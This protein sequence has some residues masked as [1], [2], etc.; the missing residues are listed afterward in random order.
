M[1]P[2]FP[3]EPTPARARVRMVANQLRRRDITD[4]RVL[5]AMEQVPRD[6]FVPEAV[7][8]EAYADRPLPIGEGQTISQPYVVALMVQLLEPAPADR[9]LEIGTGSGYAAAVLG[10]CVAEVHTVERL[11]PLART[12][13]TTLAGLGIANVI[14]HEGD[15]TLGWPDAAPYQGIL[16]SAAGPRV[17]D[18][19]LAQLAPGGRLVTP[20]GRP[21]HQELVRVRRGLDGRLRQEHLGGVSFVPLIGQQGWER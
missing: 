20:V 14:V 9:V 13:T 19:L 6:R 21:G 2:P 5:A 4:P 3:S 8:A 12:A 1:V 11:G 18:A 16:V 15:G 10:C 17:P 7:A